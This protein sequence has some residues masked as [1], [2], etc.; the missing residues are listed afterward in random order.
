MMEGSRAVLDALAHGAP[1][2]ELFISEGQPDRERLEE[3]ARRSGIPVH[4]V[5]HQVAKALS[6]AS[7][8]QGV[9][10]VAHIPERA[11]EDVSG[12]L[13]VV[14]DG[15]GD[16]GNAGTIVRSAVAAGA[17]GV[18]FS[19]GSVDPYGPKTVRAAAGAL[20][21]TSV[22][23]DVSL[24]DAVTSARDAGLTVIG[25]NVA[26]TRPY[27]EVDL[28]VPFALVVGNE[29]WGVPHEHLD[30]MDETVTIPM[31]GDAESLNVAT[32]TSIVLFE[33]LRQ[34]R[35]SSGKK[36]QR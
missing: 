27:D 4:V 14:L 33:A 25:T 24:E 1:I 10:A 21:S 34:R 29:A 17:S 7:T 30:L 23:V 31:A 36:D 15:V 26:G 22:V 28:T 16:P 18:V 13:V 11:I 35:L 3:L 20:F 6:D 32:A 9:V 12:D 19:L 2:E 5:G 8:P